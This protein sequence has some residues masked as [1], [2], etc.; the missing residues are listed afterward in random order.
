M[1]LKINETLLSKTLNDWHCTRQWLL[2]FRIDIVFVLFPDCPASVGTFSIWCRK[3]FHCR[4]SCWRETVSPNMWLEFFLLGILK[5]QYLFRLF[6]LGNC[7][8]SCFLVHGSSLGFCFF[9]KPVPSF[10]QN[11]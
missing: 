11:P 10:L 7:C 3:S 5:Q 4:K 6:L 1:A 2:V 9:S 8:A